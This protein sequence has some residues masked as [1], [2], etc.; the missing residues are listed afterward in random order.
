MHQ[1]LPRLRQGACRA[2]SPCGRSPSYSGRRV[3]IRGRGMPSE[4]STIEA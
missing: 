2:C 4:T 1:G 3:L